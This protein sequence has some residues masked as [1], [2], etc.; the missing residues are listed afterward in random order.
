[1]LL[2]VA[3]NEV[4]TIK[5][6]VILEQFSN[7]L[8]SLLYFENTEYA[9][10]RIGALH[11]QTS[12]AVGQPEREDWS[13]YILA[14]SPGGIIAEQ[15]MIIFPTNIFPRRVGVQIPPALGGGFA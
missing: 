1:M 15:V 14:N 5:H 4:V 3:K 9:E 8:L 6:K 13:S 11:A 7:P 10:K 2:I 12:S